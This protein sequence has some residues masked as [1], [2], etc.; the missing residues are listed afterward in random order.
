MNIE[1]MIT[2]E[3]PACKQIGEAP[4]SKVLDIQLDSSYI[5]SGESVPVV[6]GMGI[7]CTGCKT[8]TPIH[9]EW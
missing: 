5:G 6:V 7:F 1:L 9:Y 8:L 2:F 4:L 3:C